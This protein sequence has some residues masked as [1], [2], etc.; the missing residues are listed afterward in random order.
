MWP[1]GRDD[2]DAVLTGTLSDGDDYGYSDSDHGCQPHPRF[3]DE[4]L[5][6]AVGAIDYVGGSGSSLLTSIPK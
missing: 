1:G 6:S 2:G 5:G 4:Q 3:F